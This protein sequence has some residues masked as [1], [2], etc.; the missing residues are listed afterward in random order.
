MIL[1]EYSEGKKI[2]YYY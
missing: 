2:K 1:N